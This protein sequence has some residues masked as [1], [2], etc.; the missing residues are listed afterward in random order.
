MEILAKL[1]GGNARVKVIRWF[2]LNPEQVFDAVEMADRARISTASARREIVRLE[3][4][5]LVRKKAFFVE[6][7]HWRGGEM[8][9]KKKRT[10]G[11]ALNDRFAYLE[12][13]RDLMTN[14][15]PL[16]HA[17][18]LRKFNNTGKIKLVVISGVLIQEL[19]S[20]V[21]ILVVGDALRSNKLDTAIRII[22]SEV[23][24]ELNYTSFDTAEF[25]YR[26]TMYDRL[27]RDV[28][29]YPHEV[30]LDRLGTTTEP[31][32]K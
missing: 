18:I 28:L 16:S 14:L 24:K 32:G 4:I 12:Q 31:K 29:D 20:R 21:D 23:G 17:E 7:E 6:I 30:V 26:I 22:E 8:T 3:K 11:W 1:F 2:L 9:V 25:Q 13:L 5:G 15:P 19:E 27:I 10:Q